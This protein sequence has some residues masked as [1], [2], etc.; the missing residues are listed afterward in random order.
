MNTIRMSK[1]ND[2][3]KYFLIDMI[4]VIVMAL[5]IIIMEILYKNFG[6]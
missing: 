5:A 6:G 4:P 1:K 2:D 3:L